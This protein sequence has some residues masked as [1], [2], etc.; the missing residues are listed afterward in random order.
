MKRR[1]T[2]AALR[3]VGLAL[4]GVVCLSGSAL[5]ADTA[6]TEID[7]Y[8]YLKLDMAYDTAQMSNGNYAAFVQTYAGDPVPMLSIT[9]RQ[10]RLGMN[11]KREQMTGKVEFDFYQGGTAENASSK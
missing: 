5:A 7:W 4:L 9:A 6:A 8:G 1:G 3:A 10:T 2:G 11:V